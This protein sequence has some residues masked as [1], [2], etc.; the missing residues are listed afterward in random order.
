[1]RGEFSDPARQD[2]LANASTVGSL[3]E[4]MRALGRGL[5]ADYGKPAGATNS[6]VQFRVLERP[7][8]RLSKE[9]FT[10]AAQGPERA[11][12]R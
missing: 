10:T 3:G 8:V 11:S 5:E 4:V 7:L 6:R 2:T 9:A 1:V 12:T